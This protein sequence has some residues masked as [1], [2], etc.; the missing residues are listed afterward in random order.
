MYEPLFDLHYCRYMFPLQFWRF[1]FAVEKQD[2]ATAKAAL[3][4]MENITSHLRKSPY[5]IVLIFFYRFENLRRESLEHYVKTFSPEKKEIME[6]ISAERKKEESFSVNNFIAGDLI[7]HLDHLDSIFDG[8]YSDLPI[9]RYRWLFPA[10]YY[11]AIKNKT[12]FLRCYETP[13]FLFIAEAFEENSRIGRVVFSRVYYSLAEQTS[14]YYCHMFRFEP[15]E[16]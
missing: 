10:G 14:K 2:K 8:I 6:I 11:L 15:E 16:E 5:L 7:C 4:R 3:Q 13:N 9:A 1:R 12:D